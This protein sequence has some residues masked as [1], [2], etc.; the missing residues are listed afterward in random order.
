MRQELKIGR[1]RECLSLIP[2]IRYATVPGWCGCTRRDLKM[3]IIAPKFCGDHT[4]LPTVLWLCGGSFSTVDKAVWLPQLMHLAE[5]GYVICSAEYRTSNEAGFPAPL[6]DVKSAI[7]YLRAHAKDYAVDTHRIAVMGESAGGSLAA[8]AGMAGKSAGFDVGE[9]LDYSSEVGAVVDFY[10]I[11]DMVG[12]AEIV[13]K[14]QNEIETPWVLEAFLGARF[15]KEAAVA[16]SA[17]SYITPSVP[18]CLIFHGEC[19]ALVPVEQSICLYEALNAAGV[20]ADLYLLADAVHGDDRF[21]QDEVFDLVDQFFAR[22]FAAE[23]KP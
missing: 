8:L 3:D 23:K 12:M 2:D 15:T 11:A 22:C 5:R 14:F 16:A 7:R 10:G 20:D 9:Y 1:A 13:K 6:L 19:D 17:V 18:P 21:Y 4:A